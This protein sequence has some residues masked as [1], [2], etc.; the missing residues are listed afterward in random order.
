MQPTVNDQVLPIDSILAGD[1]VDV[2][3]RFPDKSIDLVF[4]DPPFNTKDDI[5][6]RHGSYGPGANDNCSPVEYSIF[7]TQWFFEARRISKRLLITPGIANIA[8]YPPALWTIVISKPSARAFS[9]FGGFN[10]WEPLLV[11]DKPLKRIP[12]DVIEFDAMTFTKDGRQVHPCPDNIKML[13][14]VLDKWSLVDDIVLDPF[15][16]SGT[17]ALASKRTDR[18]YIG[19]EINPRFVSLARDQL[20]KENA[21]LRIPF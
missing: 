21:F 13:Y 9:R 4:A 1:C 15:L 11:Y 3:K 6:W 14:W 17:T 19:I 2:M 7:C 16:G 12:R 10:C 18:H 5:G 8:L 20:A